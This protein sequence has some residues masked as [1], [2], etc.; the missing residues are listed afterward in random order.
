MSYYVL[1]ESQRKADVF[2]SGPQGMTALVFSSDQ[3]AQ[4]F[5]GNKQK[6][7]DWKILELDEVTF[8][9]WLTS[10]QKHK[11]LD[12]LV[13]DPPAES[14]LSGLQYIPLSSFLLAY[15]LHRS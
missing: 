1:A 8:V 7:S 11:E 14:D 10:R 15:D 3:L 5:I 2:F 9:E 12:C 6:T 13:K 4:D